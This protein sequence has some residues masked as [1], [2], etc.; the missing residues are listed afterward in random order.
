MNWLVI[1]CFILWLYILTV[2]HRGR[3]YYFK[4]LWGSVGVFVFMCIYIE[5]TLSEILKQYV[6]SVVGIL[7][8]LTGICE[9]FYELSVVFIPKQSE[10][11][12]VSLY[13]DYECSGIIE[14]MA[15]V[16]LLIFFE[17]YD[18]GQRIIISFV[19]CIS[20]FVFNIIRIMVICAVIYQF[21]SGSYYIAHTILGRIIFY[22]L[23]IILYYYVFT[24]QQIIKQKIGGF[25]YAEHN[26]NVSE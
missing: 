15:F 11:T 24:R 26:E 9:A 21:G 25:H 8:K 10:L 13:I 6:T 4:Y 16:A 19:G 22:A 18:I 20:I 3:L 17:V 23:T 7:G 12:A 14:M 2:F 1:I 5:P